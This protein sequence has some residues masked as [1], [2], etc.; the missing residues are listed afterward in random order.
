MHTYSQFNDSYTYQFV[1]GHNDIC[2]SSCFS[3]LFFFEFVSNFPPKLS[4]LSRNWILLASA[5]SDA[6]FVIVDVGYHVNSGCL[7][8]STMCMYTHENSFNY[9]IV[10]IGPLRG[11]IHLVLLLL[12][13][14]FVELFFL[15]SFFLFI[16]LCLRFC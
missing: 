6:Y 8:S 12:I 15:G 3:F 1:A 14:S 10:F 11:F 5:Y 9:V 13:T 2:S 16:L 4:L 7:R